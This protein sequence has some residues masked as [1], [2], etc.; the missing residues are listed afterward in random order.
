MSELA[1]NAIMLNYYRDRGTVSRSLAVVKTRASG[2][3]PAMRQFSIG[4]DGISV[5]DIA[6]PSRSPAASRNP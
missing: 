1:D 5:G 4:P 3:D 2:H 6:V